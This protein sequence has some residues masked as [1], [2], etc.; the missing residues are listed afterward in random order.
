[1][2]LIVTEISTGTDRTET[3]TKNEVVFIY[4]EYSHICQHYVFIKTAKK[5][6]LIRFYVFLRLSN[7]LGSQYTHSNYDLSAAGLR[8]T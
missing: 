2:V 6:I 7:I 1:M 4:N 3:L 8:M 5:K